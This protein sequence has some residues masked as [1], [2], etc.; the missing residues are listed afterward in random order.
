MKNED[1]IQHLLYELQVL[2]SRIKEHGSGHIHTTIG[3]LEQRIQELR[4]VLDSSYPDGDGYWNTT[5]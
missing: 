2:R 1:H 4:P 3:V 5:H